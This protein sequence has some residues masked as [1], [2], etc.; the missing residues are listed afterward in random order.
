ME[1]FALLLA[2]VLTQTEAAAPPPPPPPMITTGRRADAD[3]DG[4]VTR[5]EA[6][7]AFDRLDTNHDGRL[8]AEE[9][10]A[11]RPDRAGF[12][13]R[14]G[15]DG[16][17]RR[18]RWGDRRGGPDGERRGPPPGGPMPDREMT[19]ADFL[20]RAG[21]RFDRLDT[22]HDGRIDRAEIA[23]ARAHGP[24]GGPDGDGPPPSAGR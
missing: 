15:R 4:V 13:M 2:A 19:R 8:T 18:E 17:D 22:N 24:D 21:D 16:E 11:G 6:M 14:G 23:A 7:A 1:P 3:G 12:A 9:R 5:E 10:R 20:A